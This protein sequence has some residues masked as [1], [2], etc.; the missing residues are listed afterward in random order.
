M[1]KTDVIVIGGGAAGML[2]ARAAALAGADVTLLERNPKL[3]RKIYITG[4][5]RCNLTNHCPVEEVLANIPCHSRFVTGAMHRLPPTAVMSLLNRWAFRSRRSAETVYFH[6]RTRLPT[7]L[8][9]LLRNCAGAGY[10][11]YRT[12]RYVFLLRTDRSPEWKGRAAAIPVMRLCLLPGALP[13]R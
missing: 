9:P 11:W 3:G 6:N 5:G 7:L 12:G 2:A 1:S 8:T 10:G 13:I 4:K